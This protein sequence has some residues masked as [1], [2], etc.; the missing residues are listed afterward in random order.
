VAAQ[1]KSF[2]M[3]KLEY[4][5][6]ICLMEIIEVPHFNQLFTKRMICFYIVA[7]EGGTA[8]AFA[9]SSPSP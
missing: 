6:A 8:P 9:I 1:L 3:I 4:S 5:P 2:L 7:L